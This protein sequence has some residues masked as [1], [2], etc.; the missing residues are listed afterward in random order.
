MIPPPTTTTRAREGSEA[1]VMTARRIYTG[2]VA[3]RKERIADRES[4]LQ[5]ALVALRDACAHI[6]N[7]WMVRRRTATV[8]G[9]LR[10]TIGLEPVWQSLTV[11]DVI[12]ALGRHAIRPRAVR[13]REDIEVRALHVPSDVELDLVLSPKLSAGVRRHL[14]SLLGRGWEKRPPGG[15][16]MTK[17]NRQEK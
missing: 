9:K 16:A 6:D 11:A 12:L 7:A 15:R 1:K 10:M 5:A 2:Q 13:P 4:R 3:S 14:D 17:P 8:G